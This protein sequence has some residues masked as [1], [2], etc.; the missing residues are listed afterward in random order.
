MTYALKTK[1]YLNK[2]FSKKKKNKKL[3]ISEVIYLV[4]IAPR[5]TRKEDEKIKMVTLLSPA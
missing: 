5:K 3:L 4:S 2:K 1:M